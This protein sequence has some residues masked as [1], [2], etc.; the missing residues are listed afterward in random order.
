[1]FGQGLFKYKILRRPLS[2]GSF[3]AIKQTR[4]LTPL[5]NSYFKA[6]KLTKKKWFEK[7]IDMY[8]NRVY[9]F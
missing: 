8:R 2:K 6:V 4:M 9:K 7:V 5:Q 3:L 1:M